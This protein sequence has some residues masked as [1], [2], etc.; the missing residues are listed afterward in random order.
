MQIQ[1]PHVGL[2]GL[3][4]GVRIQQRRPSL[5]PPPPGPNPTPS[6]LLLPPNAPASNTPYHYPPSP[7]SCT[8]HH[9]SVPAGTEL[10][11]DA[12]QLPWASNR[13]QLPLK[14]VW[15][16][17]CST[18]SRCRHSSSGSR[19]DCTITWING[20]GM[21]LTLPCP[22]FLQFKLVI[23]INMSREVCKLVGVKGENKTTSIS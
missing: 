23:I 7:S 19:Q 14:H 16:H 9:L 1:E 10:G 18:L 5:I 12:A 11:S 20:K 15:Q 21:N 3:R 4:M 6:A 17:I 8:W 2:P 22:F 13:A